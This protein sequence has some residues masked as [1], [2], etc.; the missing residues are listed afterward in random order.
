MH[1]NP[2]T[3]SCKYSGILG[4]YLTWN[5]S[6]LERSNLERTKI[7]RHHLGKT[8]ER[9]LILLDNMII[10][11]FPWF[12][13]N[14]WCSMDDEVILC[15]LSVLLNRNTFNISFHTLLFV[16]YCSFGCFLKLRLCLPGQIPAGM[17]LNRHLAYR[18]VFLPKIELQLTYKIS[19]CVISIPTSNVEALYIYIYF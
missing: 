19:K 2:V 15:T 12:L 4:L 18:M 6:I 17:P 14:N 5:W 16:I 13:E 3:V 11:W 10:N 1:S 8:S 9:N 7:L